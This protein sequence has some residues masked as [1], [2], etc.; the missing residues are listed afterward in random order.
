MQKVQFASNTLKGTSG[1]D[2]IQR[3]MDAFERRL[4]VQTRDL[5][6][7]MVTDMRVEETREQLNK[8]IKLVKTIQFDM[9]KQI[10]RA[11]RIVD[12]AK[13]DKFDVDDCLENF[14]ERLI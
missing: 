4:I 3:R 10:E 9:V 14:R 2:D 8:E 7:K 13:S 5:V 11:E 1:P 6:T 12:R